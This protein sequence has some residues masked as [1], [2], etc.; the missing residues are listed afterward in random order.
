MQIHSVDQELWRPVIIEAD[1][2]GG[3]A[4]HK[5]VSDMLR[6][7]TFEMLW[8]PLW[9]AGLGSFRMALLVA[10]SLLKKLFSQDFENRTAAPVS[11]SKN[12]TIGALTLG[13][14][15]TVT[16]Q[17]ANGR[18]VSNLPARNTDVCFPSFRTNFQVRK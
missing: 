16:P 7:A 3:I 9:V 6:A 10:R 8:R 5:R 1:G 2:M 13:I 15:S 17:T 14:K 12:T 4:I 11:I 18:N